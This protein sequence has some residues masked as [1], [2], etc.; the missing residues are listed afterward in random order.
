MRIET[1]T[2]KGKEFAV[3]PVKHLRRLLD[4]AE[5]LADVRAYD[6]AKARLEDGKDELV[7]LELTERRLRGEAALRV[8]RE[9]RQLTQEQIAKR[10]KVSRVLIAALETKRKGGS[11]GTWKKLGAALD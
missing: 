1:V 5:M 6:A 2:R 10:S 9:Y 8:W 7:P 3:I 4:D 11:V